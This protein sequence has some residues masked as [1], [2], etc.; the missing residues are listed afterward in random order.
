MKSCLMRRRGRRA[1]TDATCSCSESSRRK[2]S[3]S[4]RTANSSRSSRFS[5][6]VG[7]QLF[8]RFVFRDLHLQE[9]VA[10]AIDDNLLRDLQTIDILVL[11]DDAFLANLLA[12]HRVER[13]VLHLGY[14][15]GFPVEE[16]VKIL[17]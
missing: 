17:V 16:D 10:V 3:P 2:T 13:L 15:S 9:L 14:Q 6:L 7:V 12:G 11:G 4:I 1:S 8:H 5:E